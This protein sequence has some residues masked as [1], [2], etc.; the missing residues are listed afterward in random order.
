M[1]SAFC[2]VCGHR[3]T[4]DS[5]FCEEC[6]I[7]VSAKSAAKLCSPP[8][9]QVIRFST[10][11]AS[12]AT[13]CL[14][15]LLVFLGLVVALAPAGWRYASLQ[16]QSRIGQHS[17]TNDSRSVG[18]SNAAPARCNQI[19]VIFAGT[20]TVTRV[21]ALLEQL[22]T[23][24]SFGPNENGAF[25]LSTTSISAAGVAAALNH[26]SDAVVSSSLLRSCL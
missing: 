24:I 3:M 18:T 25:E 5:P 4:S 16:L 23:T 13:L 11:F 15:T 14:F 7:P 12:Q 22:D 26:A 1:S 10:F 8:P 17:A 20:A 21:S 9:T 2:T 19:V 6:G